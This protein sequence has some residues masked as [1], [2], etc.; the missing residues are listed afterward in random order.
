MSVV[1]DFFPSQ[2]HNKTLAAGRRADHPSNV[3]K[4]RSTSARSET[5]RCVLRHSTTTETDTLTTMT[6][7]VGDRSSGSS[8]NNNNRVLLLCSTAAAAIVLA[9]STWWFH[10][11]VSAHGWEGTLRYLWEGDVYAPDV[12]EAMDRLE[13]CATSLA[14]QASLLELLETSLARGRLDTVDADGHDDDP[15]VI[16]AWTVAHGASNLQKDLARLNYE[17]DGA[18]AAVDAVRCLHRDARA[19]KKLLSQT[20]VGLMGRTDRLIALYKRRNEKPGSETSDR[21]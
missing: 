8:S 18:A 20:V 21:I 13:A 14:V 5:R 19:Q 15:S 2:R 16:E 9:S 1:V 4:I 17:L 11:S 3:H 7:L 6:P 12:R 10:K